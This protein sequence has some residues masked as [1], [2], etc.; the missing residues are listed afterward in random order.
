MKTLYTWCVAYLKAQKYSHF[1]IAK[2]QDVMLRKLCISSVPDSLRDCPI[3]GVP[4]NTSWHMEQYRL[5]S[6]NYPEDQ[7]K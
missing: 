2:K 6:N 7:K 3:C 4:M 5:P 1:S